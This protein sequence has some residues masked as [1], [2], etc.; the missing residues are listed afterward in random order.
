MDDCG[1]VDGAVA[2]LILGQDTVGFVAYVQD[3][4]I[5]FDINHSAF[6]NLSVSYCFQ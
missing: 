5:F 2:V 6:D 4:F 1:Q 3:G